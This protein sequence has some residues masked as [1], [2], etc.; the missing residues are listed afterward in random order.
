MEFSTNNLLEQ[1][2][3]VNVPL[4]AKLVTLRENF[5]LNLRVNFPVPECLYASYYENILISGHQDGSIRM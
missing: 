5:N 1:I 3:S 2:S 4:K